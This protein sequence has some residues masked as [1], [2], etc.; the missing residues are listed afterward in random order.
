[1]SWRV[2]A[3][4][5]AGRMTAVATTDRFGFET[6][7]PV[8]QGYRSFKIQALGAD[9]GVVGASRIFSQAVR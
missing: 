2:L 6:A 1:V 7:I 5:A 3:G 4:A 9:G 8:P